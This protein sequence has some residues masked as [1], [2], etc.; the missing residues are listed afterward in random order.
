M[1]NYGFCGTTNSIVVQLAEEKG[2]DIAIKVCRYLITD[3]YNIRWY[4]LG[5]GSERRKSEQL[6]SDNGLHEKF[7]LLGNENNPY[8]FLESCDLF[9]QTSRHEGFGLAINEARV[10]YKPII[11]TDVVGAKA[12]IE[13]GIT[14][15]IV[16]QNLEKIVERVEWCL[17]NPEQCKK[18]TDNL[19]KMKI[20][21]DESI[22]KLFI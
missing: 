5:E 8:G 11:S 14:G 6:I 7:I 22:E 21:C 20:Q 17:D 18:I 15:W 13:D 3:G 19:R 12:Q 16:S 4:V 1:N 10:L 2:Y 9:M